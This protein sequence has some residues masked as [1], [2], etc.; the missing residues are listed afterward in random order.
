MKLASVQASLI[1]SVVRLALIYLTGVALF[2]P[3]NAQ[4]QISCERLMGGN[5]RLHE[6]QHSFATPENLLEAGL[7]VRNRA[8]LIDPE[9]THLPE[10]ENAVK[11]VAAQIQIM[12]LEKKGQALHKDRTAILREIIQ[13]IHQRI[14]DKRVTYEWAVALPLRVGFLSRMEPEPR[15][16]TDSRIRI[17]TETPYFYQLS[18]YRTHAGFMRAYEFATDYVPENGR[19]RSRLKENG[20]ILF[21][22]F[23]EKVFIPAFMPLTIPQVNRLFAGKVFPIGMLRTKFR[24]LLDQQ[25]FDEFSFPIHDIFHGDNQEYFPGATITSALADLIETQS[26]KIA[27]QAKGFEFDIFHAFHHLL[28]HEDNRHLYVNNMTKSGIVDALDQN[29]D[30][31]LGRVITFNA[32]TDIYPPE[33]LAM[34]M[35]E[36]GQIIR[37][38]HKKYIDNLEKI[39]QENAAFVDQEIAKTMVGVRKKPTR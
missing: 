36:R 27:D 35:F 20:D 4:A 31:L 16:Q 39:I 28:F 25:T 23:P 22:T 13:E 9:T 29:I 34:P 19:N 12:L 32:E 26:L 10:Y 8:H 24:A 15:N 37:A 1:H 18:T 3:A 17:D 14:L 21:K 6:L 38:A 11:Q 5:A 2:V 33:L 30:A 7:S